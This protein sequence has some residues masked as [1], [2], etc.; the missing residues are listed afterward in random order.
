[1]PRPLQ[2]TIPFLTSTLD[3]EEL[4]WEADLEGLI[5]EV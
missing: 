5:W 4:I 1:M 3:P 2:I